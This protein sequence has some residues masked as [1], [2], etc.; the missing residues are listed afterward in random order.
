MLIY[1][2]LFILSV[3]YTPFLKASDSKDQPQWNSSLDHMKIEQQLMKQPIVKLEDMR[4]YL[5]NSGKI[6]HFSNQVYLATLASGLL[7]VFKP[8]KELKDAFAEVAAYKASKYLGLHLVPPTVL[9]TF[10]DQKGSLQFFAPSKYDL[11][12][13]DDCEK[14]TAL[15]TKEQKSNGALFRFIFGQWDIHNGNHII[16]SDDA[17]TSAHLALIDNGAISNTTHTRYSQHSYVR[18]F[19]REPLASDELERTEAEEFPFDRAF[20]IRF[21]ITREIAQEKFKGFTITD[22]VLERWNQYGGR[23]E[24]VIWEDSLWV[25]YYQEDTVVPNS[26]DYYS[27]DTLENLKKLNILALEKIFSDAREASSKFCTNRYLKQ[28]LSRRD[29]VLAEAKKSMADSK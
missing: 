7:G 10:D 8:E 12:K 15:L 6:A 28:I 19:Y 26:T 13:K 18:R 20:N 21:P 24:F 4:T 23:K 14:A 29:I 27:A 1:F 2:C 11:F 5:E 22:D 17:D 3:F 16:A 9:K 25:K